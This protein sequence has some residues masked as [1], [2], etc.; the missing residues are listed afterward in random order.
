MV[1]GKPVGPV[2]GVRPTKLSRLS[3][4]LSRVCQVSQPYIV[5]CPNI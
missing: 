2:P 3:T 5:K 4:K 1:R